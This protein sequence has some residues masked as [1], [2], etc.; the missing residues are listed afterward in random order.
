MRNRLFIPLA[1]LSLVTGTPDLHANEV[2]LE[3]KC[4]ECHNDDKEKGDFN[5]R[6]LAKGPT[7]ENL[8]FWLEALDLVSAEEMPPED[9]VEISPAE[10]KKL[11]A[12]IER[13]L[14]RFDS[15]AN[16][17]EKPQPRRLNNREFA[18]AVAD[19]LLLEDIGTHRPA[20]NLIGDTLHH[21]FDTH[22]ETLGFSKFHLEQYIEAVRNIVDATIL[23]GPMPESQRYEIPAERM[24]WEHVAQNSK[25]PIRWGKD[26]HLDFRDPKRAILFHDFLEAPAT[27]RYRV[28]IQCTGKDREI[29]DTKFTGYYN[30]EPIPLNIVLGDRVRSFNLPDEETTTIELDEWLA[31]GTRLEVRYPTD[32][33]TLYGNGNFKFQQSIAAYHLKENDPDGYARRDEEL[34]ILGEKQGKVRKTD[35]W[36]NWVDDWQGARPRLYS[37]VVEG[38]FYESWPPPRQIALL[39]TDPKI[40]NT[41][42]ILTP[43]A[44]RAWRR[45]ISPED[46]API[47]ALVESRAEDLGTI[48]ALKE[49]IVSILV[50]PNFLLI[51]AGEVTPADRLATKLSFFLQ[52]NAPN[53]HL[54]STAA[55][56]T[57]FDSIRTEVQHQFENNLAGEFLHAF[58]FAW[59]ELN[60][61]NFMAPDPDR[62]RF[63]HRKRIS[64]DMIA[65]VM[66]FFAHA[67]EENLPLPEF[68][69]ADY[70]FINAD[71]ATIYDASDDVPMD[72]TFRKYTFTDGRR[73]GLLGMGA[74]LTATADSLATSPIHRAVY[75]MENFMGIHPT[76]PPPDVEITE[77]DVRQART[78]KEVLAAHVADENCMSCHETIDPWGYAFENFDPT[79]AWRDEYTVPVAVTPADEEEQLPP[80][81]LWKDVT[82]PVDAGAKFRNGT[83]YQDIVEF[84]KHILTDA[85]RDR[86]VRCFITKLLTYANGI[87]PNDTQFAEIDAILEK[88]AEHEY[89]IVD[90][91]AAAVHSPLFRTN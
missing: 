75:V 61:I 64:E 4:S 81:K 3:E 89:R 31:A 30:T 51:N 56:L 27:G 5:L 8:D 39:G 67:I 9:D 15:A 35:T 62:Y 11:I 41:L 1:I 25:R 54:R 78:I 29:Y 88:S 28:S 57:S 60:D 83:E 45:D 12:W 36:H 16:P 55:E 49:G 46:L 66:H 34:R 59:L 32:A 52:S 26:G 23:D 6:F 20:A 47:V 42:Q 79:G 19:A 90:T 76:P 58:P 85:N 38:P 84:R 48:E 50:S 70:S 24:M 14:E 44:K 74:F 13:K 69:S 68:L 7:H 22:G 71:L 91:I 80:S 40:E 43:I 73:G 2:L 77:P 17:E 72:S 65:E 86:F 18:N 53:E 10:R 37:A 87:E 82:I 63:Y 33:F 21:G